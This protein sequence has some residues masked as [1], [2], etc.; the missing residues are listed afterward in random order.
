M[1]DMTS[2]TALDISVKSDNPVMQLDDL[3]NVTSLRKL[4]FTWLKPCPWHMVCRRERTWREWRAWRESS[5]S[6][7]ELPSYKTSTSRWTVR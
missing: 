7:L 4:Q 2:L 5:T 1:S 3:A 6:W